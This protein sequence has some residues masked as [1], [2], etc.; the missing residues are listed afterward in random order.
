MKKNKPKKYPVYSGPL[1]KKQR[2]DLRKKIIKYISQPRT[3]EQVAIK[4]QI[5]KISASA[6]LSDLRIRHD[7]E[8]NIETNTY[9]TDPRLYFT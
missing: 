7:V 9:F 8:H 5:S 6:F 2:D 4:F 3:P 1:T